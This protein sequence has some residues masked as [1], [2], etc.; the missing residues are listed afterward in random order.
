MEME[1][2]VSLFDALTQFTDKVVET[3]SVRYG[4]NVAEAKA[5]IRSEEA[6][7]GKPAA[8]QARTPLVSESE[9]ESESP[10]SPG[11]SVPAGARGRP[12]KKAKKV[13]NK[14]E[15]VADHIQN[16]LREEIAAGTV[17]APAEPLKEAPKKKVAPKKKA[18]T[19]KKEEVPAKGVVGGFP[20]GVRPPPLG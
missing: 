20:L 10:S 13:V 9:S 19:P 15:V 5:Y 1:M 11:G 6:L 18:E 2:K 12:E 3:L 16:M 4:F 17:A 8:P 14:G 7:G